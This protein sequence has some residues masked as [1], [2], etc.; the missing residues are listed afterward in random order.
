[1]QSH[2]AGL[3]YGPEPHHLDHMAPLCAI[4]GIPLLVTEPFLLKQAQEAYPFVE[5]FYFDYL[6]IPFFLIENY[7]VVFCCFPRILFNEL[8]FLAQ[9]L[10]KKN[11]RT[12]WCP[13]GNSDK[14]NL[15]P[16]TQALS[17]EELLLVY[18][19]Q[20]IDFFTRNK[21]MKPY[22]ITGN[23]R[24]QF[25]LQHKAWYDAYI[26]QKISISGQ[27]KTILYAPT[28]RDSEK[29][30]SFFSAIFHILEKKPDTYTLL[31]KPHPNLMQQEPFL[32]EE[33]QEKCKTLSHVYFIAD[34][35]PIYPL[36][37]ICDL[38]V[39]DMSSIGYDFLHVNRPMFFLN[40]NN[41]HN[42]LSTYLFRCGQSIS[43][44]EYPDI[45]SLIDSSEQQELALIREEVYQYAFTSCLCLKQLKNRIFDLLMQ[46]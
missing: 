42:H 40:Q 30:S 43:C 28:W 1:M 33:I 24:Y 46:R 45:Y 41:L 25:Y 15:K 27:R 6:E 20:M 8:F 31:I 36:L 44:K 38:Y 11:M 26:A 4:L 21:L 39:G 18:G 13:H 29:S 22:I 14:G 19:Q 17:Q 12:V 32:V 9:T 23:F 35:A 3:V 16:Y 34:L 2:S 37:N 5:T 10:Y 7:S